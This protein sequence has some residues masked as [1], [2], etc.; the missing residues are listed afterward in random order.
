MATQTPT[1]DS[2]PRWVPL[3]PLQRRVFGVMI[4]KAKTTPANYPMTVN[5][6]L[7]GCNQ[8]NNREPVMALESNDVEITLNELE[9]LGAVSEAPI[10]S[11][12]VKYRHHA[13]QWLGVDRAEL[14]VM[15]ELLLR[16]EQTLGELRGRAARMEP[17]ADLAA[18]EPIVRALLERGLMIA[19][20]GP[21]RGQIVSHNLYKEP[22]IVALKDRFAGHAVHA[23]PDSEGAPARQTAPAPEL[24]DE[25]ARLREQVRELQSRS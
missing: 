12:A 2:R 17:I 15:T 11:R 14:A 25:V 4:E 18:L 5:A 13:Y 9:A 19:L 1:Q 16:G 3:T 7:V 21:G 8:K 6:I 10:V 23:A 22:E 20:T 24:R